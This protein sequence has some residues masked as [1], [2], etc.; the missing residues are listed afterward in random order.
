MIETGW[1]EYRGWAARS[2][3]LQDRLR[4]WNIASLLC[5]VL[6]AVF[7]GL[8]VQLKDADPWWGSAVAAA[9]AVA[10]AI[11]PV[12]G[13]EIM[14]SGFEK[15]WIRARALAEAIKSQC[16]RVAARIPPYDGEDWA[17][18]FIAWR[19]EMTK[20]APA[21]GLTPLADPVPA[22][23]DERRP[24]PGMDIGWYLAK[25]VEGQRV[26]YTDKQKEHEDAAGLLRAV[27]IGAAVA[28]A[29]LA[30]LA[31]S[32]I[33]EGSG[34][35]FAAWA[36]VFVTISAAILAVGL[37]DRRASLAAQYG[38]MAIA[39]GRMKE[40][41]KATNADLKALVDRTESLLTAE[42]AAWAQ[43]MS[44]AKVEA[45]AEGKTDSK[46]KAD[47]QKS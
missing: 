7:G 47:S 40:W 1:D 5:V 14:S 17:E 8:A 18:R 41:Q 39:L 33:A 43:S 12:V 6:A 29:V 27:N 2:R 35:E 10:A 13:R 4:K 25:R 9:A 45:K 26:Y 20:V 28:A 24:A 42:H 37:L 16:F 3:Q 36:G 32:R 11:A 23:G 46:P 31:A 34:I 15:R 21:E 44:Q 38:A 22:A 30:A 19:D